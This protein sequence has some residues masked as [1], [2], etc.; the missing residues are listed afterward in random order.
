[1]F[2]P[3][4]GRYLVLSGL[5]LAV[6]T[7]G[8][9]AG[10]LASPLVPA[11]LLGAGWVLWLFFVVFFRDPERVPGDGIVAAADGRIVAVAV[12]GDRV[13]I[14]TFMAVTDVH[15]NRLPVDGRFT[16]IATDGRGHRPAYVPDADHNLQRHYTIAT[17]LGSIEVVQMTGLVARRLVS[18]VRVGD[19]RR[20]GERFGLIV[21]GSR[22]DVLLPAARVTVTVR[23]GDRVRAGATTIA[24]ERA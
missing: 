20:K 18:L 22:V 8:L 21:L 2:A 1:M 15:V 10:W 4:S 5:G 13:R 23:P 16:A 19:E 3:G 6:L 11:V 7:V 24:R 14:A 12:D 9:A 17:A